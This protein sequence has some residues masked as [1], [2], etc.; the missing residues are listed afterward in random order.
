MQQVYTYIIVST[1]AK[2]YSPGN[3]NQ[4]IKESLTTPFSRIILRCPSSVGSRFHPIVDPPRS[5]VAMA[6]IC[7]G[8]NLE[9]CFKGFKF[10]YRQ[11]LGR[12]WQPGW[13]WM[14]MA[15]T[16]KWDLMLGKSSNITFI[17]FFGFCRRY[18]YSMI[19]LQLSGLFP[20]VPIRD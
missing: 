2:I 7:P 9:T 4:T 20:I 8:Y 12:A 11:M 6:C 5:F 18:P 14:A 15:I 10:P 17:R 13:Q 19:F 16:R 3:E 1:H